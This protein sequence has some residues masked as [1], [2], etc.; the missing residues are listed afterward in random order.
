LARV[1]PVRGDL[2]LPQ[3]G[4]VP[5]DYGRR[6]LTELRQCEPSA[7]VL[8]N[9]ATV[10]SA[11]SFGALRAA[12]VL[13]TLTALRVAEASRRVLLSREFGRLLW[14]GSARRRRST[15]RVWRWKC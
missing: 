1:R 2:S 9:G 11:S 14:A 3:F 7:M 15:R 4:L 8:H 13:G 5:D 12:N 10:S 6:W